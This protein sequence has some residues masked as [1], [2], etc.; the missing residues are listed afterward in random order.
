MPWTMQLNYTQYLEAEDCANQIDIGRV[1]AS[2]CKLGLADWGLAS[3][4]NARYW[5]IALLV[6]KGKGISHVS[7]I[8]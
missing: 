8:L 5:Y 6:E 7:R 1:R 3:T 2:K 4:A